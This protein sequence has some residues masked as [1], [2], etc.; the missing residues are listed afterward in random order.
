VIFPDQKLSENDPSNEPF[1][2]RPEPGAYWVGSALQPLP[3][4]V[5][6]G[7]A[8]AHTSVYWLMRGSAL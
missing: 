8:D 3:G 6:K 2:S 1:G 5:P 7:R 4:E